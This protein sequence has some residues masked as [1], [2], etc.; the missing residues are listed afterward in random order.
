MS[1]GGNLQV[2]LER[3]LWARLREKFLCRVCEKLRL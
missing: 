1:I 2:Y 3:R